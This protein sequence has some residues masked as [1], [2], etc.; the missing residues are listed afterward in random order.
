MHLS[1]P[2]KKRI[3]CHVNLKLTEMGGRVLCLLVTLPGRHTPCTIYGQ[4]IHWVSQCPKK[5]QNS[6]VNQTTAVMTK[7]SKETITAPST[8]PVQEMPASQQLTQ[9]VDDASVKE[10]V[11]N[12]QNQYQVDSDGFTEVRHDNRRL[13]GTRPFQDKK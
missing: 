13:K 3:L 7:N 11:N 10:A 2:A 8:D 4:D 12:L 6:T 1:V 9:N 5:R